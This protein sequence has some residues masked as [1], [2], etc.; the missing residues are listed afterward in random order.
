VLQTLFKCLTRVMRGRFGLSSEHARY[1]SDFRDRVFRRTN[2]PTCDIAGI[3]LRAICSDL[4]QNHSTALESF[5]LVLDVLFRIGSR[6]VN[7]LETT[8]RCSRTSPP[9]S[10][11]NSAWL[12]CR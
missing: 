10:L 8:P 6:L 4:H 2:F 5:E 1:P 7:C 9:S 11:A 3:A 12:T